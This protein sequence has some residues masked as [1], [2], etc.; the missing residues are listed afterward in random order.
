MTVSVLQV[1]QVLVFSAAIL[2]TRKGSCSVSDNV[3]DWNI[4]SSSYHWCLKLIH[5]IHLASCGLF[6]GVEMWVSF[7]AGVIKFHNLP[8]HQFGYIQTKIFPVYFRTTALLSFLAVLTFYLEKSFG[9]WSADDSLQV[10]SL[11]IALVGAVFCQIVLEPM[12][13]TLMFECHKL[14]KEE[15]LGEGI[16]R[17][18]CALMRSNKP[19]MKKKIRFIGLHVVTVLVNLSGFAAMGFHTWHL[20]LQLQHL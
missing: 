14:E 12:T 5:F 16:G 20:A 7:F 10:V 2:L 3:S 17:F 9:S 15:G 8:R 6:L 19:Y 13:T 1:G 11:Y 4:D 18:D